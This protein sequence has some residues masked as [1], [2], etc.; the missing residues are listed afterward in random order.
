MMSVDIFT[1]QK[2][3]LI[4]RRHA[5]SVLS[6][7]HFN[8]MPTFNNMYQ[9][10]NKLFLFCFLC[11]S[12]LPADLDFT[13]EK[14]KY[15]MNWLVYQWLEMEELDYPQLQVSK[16]EQ[17][18]RLTYEFQKCLILMPAKYFWT[19]SVIFLR[20]EILIQKGGIPTH[21]YS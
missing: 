4:S 11:T 5:R 17:K 6:H 19:W 3:I 15:L 16:K 14:F 20:H 1:R 2:L 21:P 13:Y 12:L 18:K 10:Y 9:H 8:I 7:H